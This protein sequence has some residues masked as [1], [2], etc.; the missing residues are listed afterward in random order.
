MP[1][2]PTPPPDEPDP[3]PDPDLVAYL[4]GELPP[5]T[6]RA[7]QDRLSA[8]A[9]ARR[10]A[11]ALKKT[12]DLLDHLPKPAPSPTFASRTLTKLGTAPN[13]QATVAHTAVPGS[14]AAGPITSNRQLAW[15]GWAVAAAVAAGV[16]YLGHLLARPHLD[17]PALAPRASE[18]VRLL[19]RLPLYLGVDDLQFARQLDDPDLFADADTAPGP[20]AP[21]EAVT[22][23]ELTTL[24]E[25]FKRFPPARQDQ[26]RRLDADV[27][28]D[29][30]DRDRLLGVMER[31]AV[32]LDRL[33]DAHRKEILTE[34]SP[35]ERLDAVR[36][37]RARQWRDGLPP[38]AREKLKAAE[39]DDR[40]R[41]TAERKQRDAD[42]RAMWTAARRQW[43]ALAAGQRPYPFVSDELTRQVNEYVDK[44]LRPRL[45]L[46]ERA[47]LDDARAATQ[48]AG[49]GGTAWWFYGFGI[50][51]ALETHP[52]LPPAADGKPMVTTLDE[53]RKLDPVLVRNLVG[54]P[55]GMAKKL[56][57]RDWRDAPVFGK[58]PDFALF[59]LDE[60][61]KND[62][63]P[64]VPL[65]PSRP[66][67]Y[68]LGVAE[69]I[70]TK[71]TDADR[72][73][74]KGVEGQWPEHSRRLM[75]I[76]RRK[77]LPVPGVSP[78]G[79]PRQW[80]ET[81]DWRGRK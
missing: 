14:S 20:A 8:D 25:M 63:S 75:Q 28:A 9:D 21:E 18:Q 42:R 38:A 64:R 6:S 65:G 53:L 4:D 31:Y 39:P 13:S 36:R 37:V 17:G 79:S 2:D 3:N 69:F 47:D 44:H 19:E 74:L 50:H 73:E 1:D 35:D 54:G 56:K 15:L 27:E 51:R 23:A 26:L 78:P 41:L 57:D 34:P 76:A 66:N 72:Q 52:P 81:Y 32:W 24:E 16:G 46:L 12:F 22:T 49:A 29:P 80:A 67:E 48:P 55:K 62:L 30:K 59:V 40:D 77:D 61:R 60:S 11:E 43:A 5:D 33:P 58:W 7:V 71:L 70:A 10:E 45:S 68:V